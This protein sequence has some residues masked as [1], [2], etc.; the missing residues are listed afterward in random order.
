MLTEAGRIQSVGVG[1]VQVC[2]TPRPDCARCAAG[3]GC[4]GGLLAKLVAPRDRFLNFPA[5]DPDLRVGQRVL[6]G[7]PGRALVVASL[8]L[9]GLPLT[10]LVAGTVL[11]SLRYPGDLAAITGAA[12]GLVVGIVAGRHFAGRAGGWGLRLLG[13]AA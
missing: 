6:I 8:C 2:V 11:A 4:G 12:V 10:G 13:P 9:Y 5:T 3:E 7:L 1:S